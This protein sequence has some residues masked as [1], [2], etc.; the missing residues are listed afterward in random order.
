MG[1]WKLSVAYYNQRLMWTWQAILIPKSYLKDM[2]F[3]K[4]VVIRQGRQ[5]IKHISRRGLQ[6]NKDISSLF[7]NKIKPFNKFLTHI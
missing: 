3:F 1:D 2:G 4:D 6:K 7:L 5:Q